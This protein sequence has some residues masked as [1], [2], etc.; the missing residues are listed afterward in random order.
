MSDCDLVVPSLGESVTEAQVAKWLKNVG[1]AVDAD[2]AVLELETEK[3]NVEVYAPEAGVLATQAVK[4]GVDVSIGA[5]LGTIATGATPKAATPP[6]AAPEPVAP[7]QPAQ[8]AQPAVPPAATAASLVD[9]VVPALGESVTEAQVANWM[10]QAGDSVDA[11]EILVEL[12]TEKVNVEIRSP[13]AGMLAETLVKAGDD[14]AIGAVVARVNKQ[15]AG[16][17]AAAAMPQAASASASATAAKA[18]PA[19]T[20]TAADAGIALGGV[21]PTGPKGHVTK[22]DVLGAMAGQTAAPSMPSM[23]ATPTMPA[24]SMPP[25]PTVPVAVTAE[26]G[27][28]VV[29]MSR[30]RQAIATRLK[31]AQNTAAMLTT[32]NEVDMSAMMALRQEYRDAFEKRHGT[33]LGFMGMFV[34]AAVMALQEYAAV[35][36]EIRD[37]NIV[38]KNYY[39]IGV[40]VGS[41]RGLVVPVLRNADTMPLHAI[42][43]SI[44]ALGAKARAGKLTP[45]ELTGGTFTITNG[46]VFGSL[47]STP[48]VNPPQSGILGMHKIQKRPVVGKN[49]AV[50]VA[51]MMYVAHSYDHRIID[52]REAV[53]FLAR[54]KDLVEDPTRLVL[55]V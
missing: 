35:N 22:G 16:T 23:P 27:E 51:P 10:K 19:A 38:F 41:D 4:E 25:V 32:F 3:A 33:K 45:A 5:V 49:D 21:A 6:P 12:E 37:N 1:D 14:V 2:E 50:V 34:K 9:V 7:A 11:D 13:V 18:G 15:A 55:D 28:E 44:A 20:K 52:G 39:D 40:A 47:L 46:G 36:A 29:P 26:R 53:L 42:E 31:Q 24:V 17:P 8:P 48:I 30:L 43:A 54:I